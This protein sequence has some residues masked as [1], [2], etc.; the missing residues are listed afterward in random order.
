MIR[1]FVFLSLLTLANPLAHA[2][3]PQPVK[4]TIDT[5]L[6]TADHKIR[7]FAFDGDHGT[8]FGSEQ[9]PKTSDHFT[10]RFEK[11]VKVKALS[12]VTGGI[13]QGQLLISADGETFEDA[14][15]FIAGV[16]GWEHA[17]KELKAIRVQTGVDQTKP[18]AL[19]E[20]TIESDP[21]VAI[22]KYP[23]EFVVDVTDAPEM[24]EWAD[25]V[26]DICVRAYPMINEQLRSEG[27]KP[28]ST[29]YMTLKKDYNG[30]AATMND[31][32]VGSVKFFKDHPDDV[33]AMVHE[34]AHVVQHYRGRNNPGWLVEGVADYVR[35]FK[36]EP[37]KRRKPDP[38]RARYDAAYQ[39]TADF[40]GYV[41]EKYD[42]EL[43][44]KLNKAMRE[45]RYREDMFKEATGKTV[46]ELGEEWKESLQAK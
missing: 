42:P 28:A 2:D 33:G 43:V 13:E 26:A 14:A 5:T 25:K 9:H 38:R 6:T 18:L 39:T 32:I 36:Y 8:F 44:L 29:I 1:L 17:G 35:F 23:V 45:G 11:P 21:P 3:E 19:R 7:Q 16:A 4:A 22:Y 46:Q 41:V 15:K 20:I 37:E 27:F 10:L 12:A 30:V 40:L 24:Q 31:R 34:T